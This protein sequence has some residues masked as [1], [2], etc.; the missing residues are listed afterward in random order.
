MAL[1]PQDI[2]E[3]DAAFGYQAPVVPDAPINGQRVP[4]VAASPHGLIKTDDANVGIQTNLVNESNKTLDPTAASRK[5]MLENAQVNL[6]AANKI[7]LNPDGTV[8]NV[9]AFT[10]RNNLPWTQGA[11]ANNALQNAIA[12]QLR[13]ET[14]AGAP[15]SEIEE[16]S[17]RFMPS[18]W[19][20][21]AEQKQKLENIQRLIDGTYTQMLPKLDQKNLPSKA[22]NQEWLQTPSG[23]K[24]RVVK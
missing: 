9:A 18:V 23:T 15:A 10:G 22:E 2:Q 19:D 8:N 5:S 17:K 6:N 11:Q 16:M 12:A 3:L 7:L 1:T 20:S 14:G 4:A 21:E 13:A 24:Y